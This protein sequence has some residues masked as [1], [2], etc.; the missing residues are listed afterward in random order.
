MGNVG[1]NVA[2]GKYS[3]LA[4][5]STGS[6]QDPLTLAVALKMVL[7]GLYRR[8]DAVGYRVKMLRRSHKKSRAGCNECKRRHVK[9]DEQR[10]KC[11]ICTLSE[12][13]C[14]YPEQLQPLPPPPP[15]QQQQPT[16][17]S[18]PVSVSSSSS[19]VTLTEISP[20]QG[21]IQAITPP[22][23]LERGIGTPMPQ[24][25]HLLNA[26]VNHT[27]ME[28]LLSFSFE[29][30]SPE[31]DHDLHETGKRAL[32]NTAMESPFLLHQ[33]LAI[34][35]RRLAILKANTSGTPPYSQL[36]VVL[37]TR[38]VSI[39]NE[40]ASHSPLTK[41]NCVA[42]LLFSTLLGRHLM[43]DMFSQRSGDFNTFLGSYIQ[44]VT[45]HKG[46][47]TVSNLFWPYLVQ[48]DMRDIMIW[49]SGIKDSPPQGH[50]LDWLR[51]LV[52]EVTD[53]APDS[54]QACVQAIQFLQVGLDSLLTGEVRKRR[55]MMVYMWSVAVAPEY[56]DLLAQR[57]PEA[58]AIFAHWALLLH[59]CRDVWHVGDSGAYLLRMIADDLGAEWGH[60]LEWPLAMLAADQC[61]D[62]KEG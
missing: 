48:S 10:P 29:D 23:P 27:H 8:S 28:L 4:T 31:L 9:C 56:M 59:C 51:Y 40:T 62:R 15:P 39:F 47:K 19:S 58:V 21:P 41:T 24:V 54:R 43:V 55:N 38:A 17:S 45:L 33:V 2:W 42:T 14:S 1:F 22:P 36:A 46:I 50:H 3:V 20:A 34:S 49:S 32:F 44:Y 26:E 30:H 61:K 7:Q 60:W 5:T 25:A 11:I 18:P 35:A 53:L 13:D 57:R 52:D 16:N 37:Q 6:C 12:R